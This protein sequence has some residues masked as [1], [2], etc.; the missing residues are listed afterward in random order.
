MN[1][2]KKLFMELME[3]IERQDQEKEGFAATFCFN[4]QVKDDQTYQVF[5]YRLASRGMF[6]HDFLFN[7]RGTMFNVTD[8]ANPVLVSMTPEKC[9]NYHEEANLYDFKGSRPGVIME[10][11]DGSLISTYIHKGKLFLKSQKSIASDQAIGAMSLLGKSPELESVMERVSK[12]GY[13]FNMELTGPQWVVVVPYDRES[14]TILN[15]RNHETGET[16]FGQRLAD[17][18]DAQDASC[19]K[20]MTVS[21]ED[22]GRFHDMEHDA[23]IEAMYCE[24]QGEGYIAELI[25]MTEQGERSR[26][27]KI[28]NRKYLDLHHA[29]FELFRERNFLRISPVLVKTVLDGLSDDIKQLFANSPERLNAFVQVEQHI[30]GLA[31]KITASLDSYVKEHSDLNA[32]DFALSVQKDYPDKKMHSLLFKKRMGKEIDLVDFIYKDMQALEIFNAPL[33]QSVSGAMADD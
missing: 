10:K 30:M 31:N 32:K 27:V 22:H 28:K 18:L 7:S 13:T 8:P 25:F 6:T 24:E 12:A 15:V 20:A 33:H 11:M 1:Y 29:A 5:F 23:M 4:Q 21:Y 16:Y 3:Y 14:L 17:F 19:L 9:F 26:M 2:S